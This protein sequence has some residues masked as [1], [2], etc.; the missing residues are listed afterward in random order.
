VTATKKLGSEVE[1]AVSAMTLQ[2][3]TKRKCVELERFVREKA[4]HKSDILT[5][6]P[7]R[8]VLEQLDASLVIKVGDFENVSADLSGLK[9]SHGG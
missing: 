1:Q 6:Q 2:H 8:G 3:D 9:M 7:V 5:K 4:M